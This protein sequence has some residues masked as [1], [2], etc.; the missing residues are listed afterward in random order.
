[1]LRRTYR[2]VYASRGMRI[3]IWTH[4]EERKIEER[5]GCRRGGIREGR[6]AVGTGVGNLK[7][8]AFEE[9]ERSKYVCMYVATNEWVVGRSGT[10]YDESCILARKD[11]ARTPFRVN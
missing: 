7:Q 1:M 5:Q 10:A 4:P 2:K 3:Y 9:N 11:V 8:I 6:G